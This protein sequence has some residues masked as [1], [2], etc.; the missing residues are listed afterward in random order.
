MAIYTYCS[1][2]NLLSLERTLLFIPEKCPSFA[3]HVE[4]LF[5]I[6]IHLWVYVVLTAFLKKNV[7]LTVG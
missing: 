4:K 6:Y 7:L 2:H 5:D 1:A 3:S